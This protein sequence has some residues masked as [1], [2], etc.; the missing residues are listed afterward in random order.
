MR[1]LLPS[2][3]GEAFLPEEV[4]FF[5]TCPLMGD[6]IYIQQKEFDRIEGLEVELLPS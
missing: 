2:K 4:F 5:L 3:K 6:P 1:A